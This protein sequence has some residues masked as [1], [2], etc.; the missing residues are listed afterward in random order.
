MDR[1]LSLPPIYRQ[2]AL[3][4]QKD[5]CK[6]AARAARDGAA[7]GTL[8]WSRR[9]DRADCAV[10]LEPDQP[11]QTANLI[12]YVAMLAMSDALG[13]LVPPVVSVT[14]GW[15]DRILVNG[16]VAGGIRLITAAG[17]DAPTWLVVGVT[18]QVTGD[19]NDDSPGRE[20]HRT[21]LYEEGCGK[22]GAAELLERC[23]RYFLNWVNRWQDDGFAPV[24]AAWLAR[25]AEMGEPITLD[26]GGRQYAGTFSGLDDAGELVLDAPEAPKTVALAAALRSPTWSL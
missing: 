6:E 24:K 4:K 7:D 16:A 23:A 9:A 5:P 15:P 11:R 13:A 20:Q 14:F 18:V 12:A 8:F 25:A 21:S 19:P 17:D 22:V 26:L 2:V 1:E 10:V 3:G